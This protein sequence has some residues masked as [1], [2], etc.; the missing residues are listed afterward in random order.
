[1][2]FQA[3]FTSGV[4]LEGPL[5]AIATYVEPLNVTTSF[6][7]YVALESNAPRKLKPV[8]FVPAGPCDPA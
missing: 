7:A 2:T 5:A 1:M 3:E 4:E 8:P 6:K